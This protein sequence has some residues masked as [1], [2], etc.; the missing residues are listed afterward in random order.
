MAAAHVGR[1]ID[2]QLVGDRQV[3]GVAA[4]QRDDGGEV[5]AGAVAAD[6]RGATRSRP[7]ARHGGAPSGRGEAVVDRG[8]EAVLGAHAVVDRD[9][10]AARAVGELAAE[11]VVGVEVAD[12]PAAAVEVHQHR[13]RRRVVAAPRRPVQ[14]QRDRAVRPSA[15]SSAISATGGG[16]GW[17]KGA[18][19]R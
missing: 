19:S 13:R 5:A 12:G 11:H 15:D 4:E 17:V 2:Q 8:R 10:R 14:A 9:D 6:R 3:A 7:S 18:A 1:R 16:S